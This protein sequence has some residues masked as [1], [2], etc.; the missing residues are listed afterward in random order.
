MDLNEQ[1]LSELK[2]IR[3]SQ[4][5]MQEKVIS[6]EGKVNEFSEEW[7]TN[8]LACKIL[9]YAKSSRILKT[10]KENG[11]LKEAEDYRYHSGKRCFEYRK[12]KIKQEAERVRNGGK[13]YSYL[14][15]KIKKV[16][17]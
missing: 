14:S 4:E 8:D 1:I 5:R 11:Y 16:G 6:I 2:T 7:I 9:G 12:E 17:G 3:I 13:T 10:L 15:A